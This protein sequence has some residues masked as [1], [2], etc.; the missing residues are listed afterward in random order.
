MASISTLFIQAHNAARE[1]GAPLFYFDELFV[2][3]E[4]IGTTATQY[5]LNTSICTTLKHIVFAP[6][7]VTHRSSPPSS[8]AMHALSHD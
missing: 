3:V 7:T 8:S 2:S 6:F 5:T 1:G 4:V